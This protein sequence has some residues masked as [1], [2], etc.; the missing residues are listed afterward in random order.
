MS[1]AACRCCCWSGFP[2]NVPRVPDHQF[3]HKSGQGFQVCLH[4]S[5]PEEKLS[6]ASFQTGAS[7]CVGSWESSRTQVAPHSCRGGLGAWVVLG[8]I[9][10]LVGSLEWNLNVVLDSLEKCSKILVFIS[11]FFPQS[12]CSNAAAVMLLL[13][14]SY[15]VW[16]IFFERLEL[17]LKFETML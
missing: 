1:P 5:H 17:Y 9:Q 8:I 16:C 7:A 15:R 13:T 10:F 6:F 2:V 12:I 3:T 4:L 11:E 14:G